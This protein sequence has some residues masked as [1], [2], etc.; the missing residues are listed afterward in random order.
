MDRLG[1]KVSDDDAFDHLLPYWRPLLWRAACDRGLQE[2]YRE[3]NGGGCPWYMD[4]EGSRAS[5]TAES[6]C[7]GNEGTAG[8]QK[9]RTV[10]GC[11]SELSG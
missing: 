3:G 6:G 1:Q 4:P 8:R 2:L 7:P 10:Y 11:G 9:R 5:D